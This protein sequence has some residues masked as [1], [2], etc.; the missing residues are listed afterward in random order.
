VA[1]GRHHQSD[2]FSLQKRMLP[3][4]VDM[5]IAPGRG[6]GSLTSCGDGTRAIFLAGMGG[7]QRGASECAEP[8]KAVQQ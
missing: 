7:N 4:L 2:P 5:V 1:G 3:D 8:F 6:S